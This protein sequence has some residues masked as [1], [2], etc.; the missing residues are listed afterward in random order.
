MATFED[1]G[2]SIDREVE[3]LRQFFEAEVRPTT[4]RRLVAALRAASK[5]LAKLA[6]DLDERSQRRPPAG[7]RR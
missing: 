1:V 2:R 3:K 7:E 4:E 5:R 6:E